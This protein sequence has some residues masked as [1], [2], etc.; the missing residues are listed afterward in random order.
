MPPSLPPKPKA[1]VLELPVPPKKALAVFILFTF[2]QA[3]P[4]HVSVAADL[5]PGLSPAKATEDVY[6]PPP[7]KSPLAVFKLVPEDH[8]PVAVT[9]AY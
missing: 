3:E 5:P 1:L 2:V 7:A 9:A 6:I 8:E 4:F